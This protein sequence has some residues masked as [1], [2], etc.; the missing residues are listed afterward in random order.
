MLRAAAVHILTASGACLALLALLA[1]TQGQWQTMFIW[2]GAALVVDGIDGPL[3]RRFGT[4]EHL[5]RWSGDDL[6]NIVDYLT[7]VLVPAFALAMSDLLPAGT[8][9]AAAFAILLSSL[10]HFSDTESKAA[11]NE[12]VGFPAV[13]NVVA[14]YL[15]AFGLAPVANLV[16]VV[17]LVV[18]TFVPTPYV[19]PFRS[20]RLRRISIAI[21]ALWMCAAAASLA[22]PFPSPGWLQGLLLAAGIYFAVAGFLTHRSG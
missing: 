16:I 8:G 2:L 19:H 20:T 10:F 5:A 11:S 12:F 15:F 17:V 21:T 9:L 13:W 1:A 7:Y 18:L 14:L 3:A 22:F 6:D 4:K